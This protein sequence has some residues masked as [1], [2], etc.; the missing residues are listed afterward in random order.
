MDG[1]IALLLGH[2]LLENNVWDSKTGRKLSNS[3]RTYK[4]PTALDM[5]HIERHYVP[6]LDADGPYGAKEGGLGFG[7]GL[8]GAI[9]NAIHDAVGIWVKD[10]PITSEHVLK[11]IKENE[12]KEKK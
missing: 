10:L 11:L 7:V 5:P 6:K 8:D 4:L 9:A 3:Y 2:G 1:Q 12:A